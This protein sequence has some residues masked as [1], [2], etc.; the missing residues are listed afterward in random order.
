MSLL[1]SVAFAQDGGEAERGRWDG[2]VALDV[3]H[4]TSEAAVPAGGPTPG[5]S[6]TELGMRLRG[7]VETGSVVAALDYQGREAVG[8]TFQTT[9]LRL[10]YRAE[11]VGTVAGDHLDLAAGRFV[12]PSVNFLAVDGG[13]L[14]WRPSDH[15]TVQVFGGRRGVSTTMSSLG[16][17]TVLP[18]VGGGAA[19]RGDDGAAEVQVSYAGD[20]AA[21]PSGDPEAPIEDTWNALAASLRGHVE[22][23]EDSLL[24]GANATVSQRASFV[25]LPTPGSAQVTAQALDLFQG[26]GY[27][28]WR[29]A[30]AVRVDFDLLRQE[31]NLEFAGVDSDPDAP[32]VQLPG[33]VDVTV[34]D[35]TFTDARARG[36]VALGDHGWLR[37]DLRLRLRT[38]RTEFR[39]GLGADLTDLVTEGPFVRARFWLEDIMQGGE[40]D[41]VGAVDRLLWSGSGG[42]SSGPL[43]AELGASRM[44]RAAAPVS[45]RTEGRTTSE[46]LGP[47][48]LEA[49][50]VGFARVFVTD[51]SRFG[52]WFGGLD[53]EMN[54]TAEPEVRAFVQ[55]GVLGDG[56]W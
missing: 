16:F 13:R 9:P 40:A 18:A 51:R 35:P 36:A 27:V 39:Y 30:D 26:F 37:P 34:I 33:G 38:G 54:L 31:A 56:S 41:D 4:A 20:Q 32:G 44:D 53:A 49:Q 14:A 17:D 21:L 22:A 46:D 3:L 6:A 10:F 42:W 15:V 8:G 23:L 25:F 24:V 47:F 52:G 28:R 5:L 50:D 43:E 55:I 11:V 7:T 29:P 12:A 48:V 45:G 2:E 1:W 19:L